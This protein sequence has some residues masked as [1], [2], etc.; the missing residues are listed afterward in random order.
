[1]EHEELYNA[2]NNSRP[3]EQELPLEDSG[4]CELKSKPYVG[5]QFDSRMM[6]KLFTKNLPKKKSKTKNALD[7][8]LSRDDEN[9]ALRSCLSLRTGCKAMLRVMK[10]KKLQ[11]WVV[12]GFDNNHNHGI[13]SPKSVS[14]LR[15]HKKMSTAAKSL[16]EKFSEEG[17]PTGKD[18]MM[19]NVGMNT[20]QR[21]ESINAFFDSFVNSRTTLKD[22]VVKFAKVVDNRYKKE[23]KE[24]FDSRHKTP[25]LEKVEK[26]GT[27]YRYKVTS[28]FDPDDAFIVKLNLE[29]KVYECDYQLFEC[30]G[31]VCKQML[32]IFQVKNIFQ[33]PSHYILQCWT[34]EANKELKSVEYKSSFEDEHHM[35]RALRSIHVCQ[36]VS[37][38]SYLAEKSEDIYKMIIS[39]LDH[40]LKKAFGMENELLEDKEDDEMDMHHKS[41]ESADIV[42]VEDCSVIVPLNIKDPHVSQTKG[43]KKV[44]RNRVLVGELKNFEVANGSYDHDGHP[45]R[46][47]TLWSCVAH[48]ITAVIGSGVLSLAWSAS[49]LGW[50]AGLLCFV[51]VTYVSVYLISDCYRCPDS[52]TRTRNY[53]YMDAVRVNRGR[54]AL[55]VAKVIENGKIM[56]SIT[57]V[58]ASSLANKLWLVFQALGDI[59]FAYPYSIIVLEIQDTLKS[60]PPENKTMKRASMVAFVVTTFFYLCC[61]CFGYAAIGNDTPGNLLTGFGFYE[62]YWL[63]DFA[64]A[65]IVLHLVG[66]YQIFSQP[67]FAFAKGWFAKKFPNGGF[68]NKFYTFKL[69]LLPGF[70]LNL[71]KLC[72]R[73]AYV[74]S[75][76]GIA[77]LFP[78]FNSVLGL[79]RALN[80][81]PLTIYFP[82][83][84]GTVV[85]EKCREQWSS[86]ATEARAPNK[87]VCNRIDGIF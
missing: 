67:I 27:F 85:E 34:K 57:G 8:G 52:I 86:A 43:R 64:N 7:S 77:M 18:A 55:G 87:L 82:V 20:T 19:F 5:M 58:P 38:L 6:L 50:I 68:V 70:Q 16:V 63:I 12:K 37:Q 14:Y 84:P 66:G 36:R 21:S 1:M 30:M 46:T 60:P 26:N 13:I 59:A 2:P 72:F 74:I 79:L 76:T 49:Q 78:Y 54:F 48:I 32:L 53:C 75:T 56:G 45:R 69:P 39:D 42:E 9:K 22:F 81:W 11:K 35:S 61:G 33:I 65:C 44:L 62:P 23:R 15:C 47:G 73:T 24:D 10:N 83:E 29:S 80:F 51:I 31:I 28:S 40:T 71:L 3:S 41:G 17:L 4:D 25:S